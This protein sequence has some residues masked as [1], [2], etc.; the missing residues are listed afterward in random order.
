MHIFVTGASGFV[1]G[2]FVRASAGRHT[3]TAMSRSEKADARIAALGA[4]PVRASL[5]DVTA[6]HMK[7]AADDVHRQLYRGAG[8]SHGSFLACRR[9]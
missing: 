4:V 5:D 1:G 8:V 7:G 3:F 2:A 6:E 9:L